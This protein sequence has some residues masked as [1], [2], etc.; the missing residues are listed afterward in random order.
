[1]KLAQSIN[2]FQITAGFYCEVFKLLRGF[3]A[4]CPSCHQPPNDSSSDGTTSVY[5][6]TPSQPHQ[7]ITAVAGLPGEYSVDPST[8]N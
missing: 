6:V 5:K 2:Q 1:L 4:E 3:T 8:L 7:V